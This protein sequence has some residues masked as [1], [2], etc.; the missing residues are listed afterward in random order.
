MNLTTMLDERTDCILY[1]RAPVLLS[2]LLVELAAMHLPI[3][4]IKRTPSMKA[5][6]YLKSDCRTNGSRFFIFE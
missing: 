1:Q 2:M 5:C 6:T 3:L 4:T